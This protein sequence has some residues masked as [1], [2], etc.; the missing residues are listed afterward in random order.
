MDN[1]TTRLIND[2]P[3]QKE[4]STSVSQTQAEV[5]HSKK[6][7]KTNPIVAAAG[8][9][10]V[11]AATGAATTMAAATSNNEAEMPTDII[12]E[13]KI[14]EE[15]HEETPEAPAPE[16]AILANDEGI[17]YAHVNADNFNEAFA[18][19]REQVG[20]GGVFEYNDRI[21]ATYYAEEWNEMSSQERTEFQ[22]KVYEVAPSHNS[23]VS[24]SGQVTLADH[25][26]VEPISQESDIISENVNTDSSE[27]IP[28]NAQMIATEPVDNEIRVLGVE[29]VQNGYGEIMN[30][31]L[32]ECE[33][34]QALLIDVDNNGSI[35]VLIHDD[36][37]DGQIQESEIHDISGSGLEVADLLQA[38]AAQE[39]DVYYASN[40]DMPDYI[41]D[42]DSIMTV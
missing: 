12:E 36:N 9:F 30:V 41:N 11:G 22:S 23:E 29:A 38:Q 35:D 13:E 7:K 4:Q 5:A 27:P 10:V 40:D 14:E 26:N 19:A 20:P 39:G 34:D 2:E 37:F 16:Q 3:A 33:G 25:S 1:E 28:A 18:Q 15:K 24:P 17:R 6:S 32:V 42:A 31:A 21:Y 8:G